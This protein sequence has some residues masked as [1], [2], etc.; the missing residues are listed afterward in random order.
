MNSKKHILFVKSLFLSLFILCVSSVF[1][2]D[3]NQS[4]LEEGVSA[5][6]DGD[7]KKAENYFLLKLNN[8]NLKNESLMYLSKI[9]LVK[10]DSESAVNYI[11]QALLME[12]TNAEELLL[13]GD[14]YCAQAQKSSIFTAL[15]LAK[16]CIAQYD[17][18]VSQYPDNIAALV[19][20]VK[21]HLGAPSIAGGSTKKGNEFLVRLSQLSPEDADTYKVLS[22]EK[23]G[24]ASDALALADKLAKNGFKSAENQYEV[25]RYFKERKLY[26][27]AK[28]LFEPLLTWKETQKNKWFLNDSLLQLGEIFIAEGADINQGIK[29]IES[30]KKKNTNSHDVHYFWSTWSL[31]KGYKAIGQKD[32]YDVLVRNIKSEDYK[33]NSAFAKEFESNI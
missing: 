9:S 6:N 23:E 2:A 31:A 19:S 10:N 29:L 22:L 30:Y 13:S 1:A 33:K 21:F 4:Q 18:A 32:K 27:K 3:S 20:S 17:T 7:Y 14:A 12:P 8:K 16:K 24:R 5:F 25:A 26:I 15:K 28:E 11:E